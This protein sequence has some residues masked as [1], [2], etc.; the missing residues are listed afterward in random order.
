MANKIVTKERGW[1]TFNRLRLVPMISILLLSS[2]QAQPVE[3]AQQAVQQSLKPV[4]KAFDR[5][6]AVLGDFATGPRLLEFSTPQQNCAQ[7]YDEL[8]RLTPR[9]Y[10]Y[11]LGF[12]DDPR[13]EALG[14]LGF[15]FTPAFYG[16][17]LTS[18]DEY[19]EGSRIRN[20]GMRIDSL[21]HAAARQDCWVRE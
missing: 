3:P 12:Y 9:T 16:W 6:G 20:T 14:M 10:N 19:S 13:N 17:A 8:V 15:V 1:G 7:I 5:G 18:L 21:R 11:K 2:V 4:V